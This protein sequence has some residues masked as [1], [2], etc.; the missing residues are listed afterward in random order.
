MSGFAWQ[1]VH[2]NTAKF[3]GFTWQLEHDVAKRACEPELSGKNESWLK[4]APCQLAVEWHV[5]HVVGKPAAEW[6]GLF[7]PA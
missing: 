6:T 1:P 3:E 5:A 4:V 2:V 7:V